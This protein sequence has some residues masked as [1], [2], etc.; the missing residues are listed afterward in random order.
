MKAYCVPTGGERKRGHPPPPLHL[1]HD[2][3]QRSPRDPTRTSGKL[4]NAAGG[5]VL[6]FLERTINEIR[7]N[8]YALERLNNEFNTKRRTLE[9]FSYQIFSK[10][11]L[12]QNWKIFL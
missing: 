2:H 10:S 7:N 9:I 11:N 12:S 6:Q 3:E 4:Y 1:G 8:L 5:T